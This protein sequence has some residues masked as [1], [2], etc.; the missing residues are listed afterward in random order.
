[1]E[2]TGFREFIAPWNTIDTLS[3]RNVRSASL[4][5]ATTSM[6]VPDS[7]WNVTSPLRSTAGGF[8]SR[9]RP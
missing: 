1:M 2:I 6:S 5:S 4:L 7:S 9:F 3:Q 8:R